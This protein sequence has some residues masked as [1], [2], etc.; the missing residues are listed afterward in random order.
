VT[1]HPSPV[2]RHGFFVTGTDTGVGKTV[3]ACALLHA[4]AA[5]GLR[6]AGMKPVA[7]GREAD[8]SFHDVEALIAA[9]TVRA[10]REWV[11]PY[12][13]DPPMAPHIAAA[14]AGVRISIERIRDAC[15]RLAALADSVV[16]EGAG[17][18]LVPLDEGEDMADLAGALELPVV[19]VVGMRLG[20]LNHA[21]LTAEAIAGRGLSFAG[22]VANR[23]DPAMDAFE[24]NLAT[25][26][27]Q[28]PGP[29][30]GVIPHLQP[31][32]GEIAAGYLRL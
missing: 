31:S 23:M 2:T 14:R 5:K 30:L 8:G 9:S 11:N 20:C 19:L 21:F 29:L 6:V 16:V 26:R 32:R 18:L 10:P 4:L 22:W 25:L 24:E 28:L 27:G 1:R 3:A 13:F 12:A 7:A 15:A 17:G